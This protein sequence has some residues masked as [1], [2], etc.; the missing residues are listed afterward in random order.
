MSQGSYRII[1]TMIKINEDIDKHPELI[2]NS[3]VNTP[4]SRL[5]ETRANRELNLK[6]TP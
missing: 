4:V 3:P 6:W 1:E 2:R 5:D